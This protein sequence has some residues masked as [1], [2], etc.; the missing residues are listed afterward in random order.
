MAFRPT[1]RAMGGFE[2]PHCHPALTKWWSKY[3]PAEGEI[4]RHLS[5][6]EQKII[7]PWI[8]HAPEKVPR[9]KPSS[10][11]A[12]EQQVLARCVLSQMLYGDA[13]DCCALRCVQIARRLKVFGPYWAGCFLMIYGT[14]YGSTWYEH[15]LTRA[16]R[17]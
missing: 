16:H 6:N 12:L 5:P 11:D 8:K 9:N 10:T 3:T 7:V 2:K 13:H 14:M 4:T 1:A 15:E 17:S